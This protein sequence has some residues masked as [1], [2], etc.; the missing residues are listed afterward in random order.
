M[1]KKFIDNKLQ[2]FWSKK[3]RDI[4]LNYPLGVLTKSDGHWLSGI[5]NEAFTNE[6]TARGYDVTT[7]KF[8]VMVKPEL[9]PDKFETLLKQQNGNEQEKI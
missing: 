7:L 9:R 4:M 6:L 1:A 8:S 2:A 3:E 5:F